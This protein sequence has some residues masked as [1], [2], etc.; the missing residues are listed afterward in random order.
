MCGAKH[1]RPFFWEAHKGVGYTRLGRRLSN[2]MS[3]KKTKAM[4][5]WLQKEHPTVATRWSTSVVKVSGRMHSDAFKRRLAFGLKQLSTVAKSFIT[6]ALECKTVLKSLKII[7]M[8]C[9]AFLIDE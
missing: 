3:A 4:R 2:S 9:Y 6:K 7:N 8:H 5:Y 1:T